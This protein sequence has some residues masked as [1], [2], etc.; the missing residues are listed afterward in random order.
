[1]SSK[2]LA[3]AALTGAAALV[4]LLAPLNSDAAL[5][6]S[7]TPATLLEHDRVQ[8]PRAYRRL[9]AEE[10]QLCAAQQSAEF[11]AP[12]EERMIELFGAAAL[13]VEPVELTDARRRQLQQVNAVVNSMIEPVADAQ[14]DEWRLGALAGDCEEYVLMKRELLMRLGWPRAALR[15]TVVHD[16]VGYHAVLTVATDQGDFV[17]DNLVNYVS[18]IEDSPYEFVVAESLLEPGAWTRVTPGSTTP[19]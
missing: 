2:L 8:P 18:R 1:M 3:A 9:C 10:P 12:Y 19:F 5:L 6:T 11:L 14:G 17:L 7:P 4:S 16:G 13:H 15:I